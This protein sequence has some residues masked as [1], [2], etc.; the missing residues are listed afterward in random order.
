MV[1]KCANPSCTEGFRY[2]RGGKLFVFAPKS[3]GVAP[4]G[5][6]HEQ[7]WDTEWLWLCERCVLTMTIV[8][9]RYSELTKGADAHSS[10]QIA[11]RT[12]GVHLCLHSLAQV[13][14]L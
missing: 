5:D 1:E 4:G 7:G 11:T 3:P 13:P 12:C 9:D 2:L 6:F 14:A 8:S 10:V